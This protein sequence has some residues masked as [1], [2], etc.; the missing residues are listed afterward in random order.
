MAKR[1]LYDRALDTVMHSRFVAEAEDKGR[2]LTDE[3]VKKSARYYLDTLPYS[4][5]EREFIR[6]AMRQ[7]RQLERR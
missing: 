3:E 5:Y 4:G 1:T 2:A 6:T 7:M